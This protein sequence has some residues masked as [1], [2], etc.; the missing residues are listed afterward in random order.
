MKRITFLISLTLF[1]ASCQSVTLA[2]SPTDLP[3][4]TASPSPTPTLTPTNTPVPLVNLEGILFFDYNGSGLREKNEPPISNFKTCLRSQDICVNTD[5][6][7][8]FVFSNIA[9]VGTTKYLDFVDPNA[10]NPRLAFKYINRWEGS[11]NIPAY[12]FN[13][14]QVPEQNLNDTEI[15]P[16]DEGIEIRTGDKNN[17][18]LTQGFLTLPFRSQDY[19]LIYCIGM[20]DHDTRNGPLMNY[21]GSSE[22][23]I[24]R[25]ANLPGGDGHLGTDFFVPEGTF[26]VAPFPGYIT[27]EF[28]NPDNQARVARLANT[29][30][31]D[32]PD[33]YLVAIL[34][35]HS[36]PL[37]SDIPS[38]AIWSDRFGSKVYRGQIILLSGKTGTYN[39]PHLHFNIC[40]NLI[41]GVK[42]SSD[43]PGFQC[44]DPYGIEF[45]PDIVGFPIDKL[46]LVS[47]WT[48]YNNPVSP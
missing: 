20:Y 23:N 8:H 24:G 39:A 30:F 11:V 4:L 13:S 28:V 9:P 47:D 34:G 15:I 19:N 22:P 17:I 32:R 25:C 31:I 5:E 40:G 42:E 43:H 7:G 36:T 33:Y 3:T 27:D 37:I 48:V 35:H 18:A 44:W 14:I 2:P 6:N 21:Q 41:P 29:E 1:M 12:E 38:H 46:D 16:I 45:D 10:D 26:L